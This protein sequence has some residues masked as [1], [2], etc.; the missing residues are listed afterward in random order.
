[1]HCQETSNH[2]YL[3]H[4]PGRIRVRDYPIVGALAILDAPTSL[5]SCA[6]SEVKAPFELLLSDLGEEFAEKAR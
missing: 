5:I 6:Y 1:M 2:T 3:A 4:P